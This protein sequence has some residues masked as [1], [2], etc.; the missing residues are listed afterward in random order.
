VISFDWSLTASPTDGGLVGETQTQ[1]DNPFR[2]DP[3]LAECLAES[4]KALGL[5]AFTM[6]SQSPGL[7]QDSGTSGSTTDQAAA[8]P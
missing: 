8:Q 3:E 1:G 4:T 7:Q 5:P 6:G 2:F